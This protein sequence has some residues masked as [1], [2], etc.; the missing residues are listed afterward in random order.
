MLEDVCRGGFDAAFERLRAIL[1]EGETDKKTQYSI[2]ALWDIRRN[3]FKDF[4]GVRLHSAASAAAAAAVALAAGF[5]TAGV[6]APGV[7]AAAV[8]AAVAAAAVGSVVG[9]AVLN[10]FIIY[11]YIYI[12]IV[13]VTIM[14]ILWS[15]EYN[16]NLYYI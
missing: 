13:Y 7:A 3:G 16:S 8:A 1:Q 14:N 12:H 11:I 15:K 4:P 2:E 10:V 6:A 9:V 5:A